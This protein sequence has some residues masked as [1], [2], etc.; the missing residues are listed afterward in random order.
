VIIVI[1]G[2]LNSIAL[3]CPDSEGQLCPIIGKIIMPG[4]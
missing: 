3:R 4:W 1:L 2:F